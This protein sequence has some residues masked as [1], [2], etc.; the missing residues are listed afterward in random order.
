MWIVS[1][2]VH[3]SPPWCVHV[4]SPSADV[5]RSVSCPLSALTLWLADCDVYNLPN[6][7]VWMNQGFLGWLQHGKDL[8]I[9]DN[10]FSFLQRRMYLSTTL[11]IAHGENTFAS[12]LKFSLDIP[13]VLL[14]HGIL[15][16]M[17]EIF[18]NGTFLWS[19][20]LMFFISNRFKSY[21]LCPPFIWITIMV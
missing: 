2:S 4:C 21:Y 6:L 10:R 8:L 5:D 20:S 9:F 12:T 17:N 1:T 13:G 15:I 11:R 18:T 16:Q 19:I 14:H 3:A 7:V